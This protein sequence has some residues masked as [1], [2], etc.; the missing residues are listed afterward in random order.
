MASVNFFTQGIKFSIPH[1]RKTSLWI[2]RSI[3]A[4]NEKLKELNFIFTSDQYLLGLNIQYL[5]HRTLTDVITFDNREGQ[6]KIEAD[7][8]ISIDRIKENALKNNVSFIDEL[9]RVMI[10]GVLHLLGYT[11]KTP[12]KIKVMRKKEDAYLSLR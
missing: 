10:H 4:E 1:P 9:N 6:G 8:F 7:I 2:K 3:T 12:S 11:D 5:N